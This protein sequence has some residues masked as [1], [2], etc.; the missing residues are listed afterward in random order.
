MT[1]TFNFACA[2]LMFTSVFSGCMSFHTGPMPGEPETAK[3]A[4][5]D[6]VRVRYVDVGEGS[7]V[8][9]V[10]GFASS[11]DVWDGV[12]REVSKGHR[13]LAL[14]L[15][16]FGWTDRPEGDYSPT[17]QAALVFHLM[18]ARG[19]D[20]A[21][22]VAHSWGASV[23]LAMSLAAPERVT[24]LALYDAW[25]YEEQLPPTFYWARADG[26]GEAIFGVF[27]NQRVEDKVA[28]AFYDKK[29]VTQKLV[30]ATER[31][32]ERPGTTAAALAA[33]RGQRYSQV[34]HRYKDI[35]QPA[36]LLWGRED[37]VTTLAYGERLSN[38]LAHAKL[39]VY[40]RCGHFPMVEAEAPST[41]ELL[42]FLAE[43]HLA[44]THAGGV[45]SA[46]ATGP[47]LLL[48]PMPPSST[49]GA[50]PKGP[51]GS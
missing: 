21:A 40:P 12:I 36:L 32:L 31:A 2:L 19:V 24:R 8:V 38:D 27:Y 13:V 35:R 42:A 3:F 25:V 5:I 39:V 17:A 23:A 51:S 33:V 49:G 7:P 20:R 14:D 6:G 44:Q 28:L 47:V 48:P 46:P 26:L 30:D 37:Q 22:V 16:G 10:H 34:Q 9:F 15:K 50:S 45:P 29:F 1:R 41:N 18:D 4:R 11:L 43:D